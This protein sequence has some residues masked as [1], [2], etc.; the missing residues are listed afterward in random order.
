M[1]INFRLPGHFVMRLTMLLVCAASPLSA[2]V[3][4][5]NAGTTDFSGIVEFWSIVDQLRAGREP[6][7]SA[8]DRLFATPGYAALQARERRRPAITAGMRAAFMPSQTALRDSLLAANGWTARVIR[9]VQALPQRRA[10]LDD[11][12]KRAQSQDFLG[13]AVSRAGTLLPDGTVARYGQPNV[14]FV[15]FLPDGRGYPGLIVADLAHVMDMGDPIPFFA[16]EATHFYWAQLAA[17]RRVRDADTSVSPGRD[18]LESLLMKIAE[19]AAGDQ[20]DKL[21]ATER[22]PGAL[23]RANRDSSWARYMAEYRDEIAK[24][25]VQLQRMNQA[26]ETMA[27]APARTRALS[28]SVG[29]AL[30]LEGR[31]VGMYMA[32]AIRRELGDASFKALAGDPVAFFTDYQRASKRASCQCVSFSAEAMR[33][34]RGQHS[35][36]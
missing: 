13:Q 12:M 22:N 36:G 31:P 27:A 11:F 23:V 16:H 35:R 25:D 17:A 7:D 24:A 18:A 30:P 10:M 32:R 1:R 5:P 6:A 28:D 3:G 4:R 34:I 33:M 26:L 14:A 15:F 9:H 29:E 8:W 20:F 2:Q 21:E 19:E